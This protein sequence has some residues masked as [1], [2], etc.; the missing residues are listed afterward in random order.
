MFKMIKINN[1]FLIAIAGAVILHSGVLLACV[2]VSTPSYAVVSSSLA[3][4]VALVQ[5]SFKRVEKTS[6]SLME[7][8]VEKQQIARDIKKF[9]T[10]KVVE[11][12]IQEVDAL[13]SNEDL[14][15]VNVAP[16]AT[17]DVQAKMQ[18]NRPP[19]YPREAR[20]K[21]WEGRVIV[22]IFVT[23]TGVVKS[24]SVLESSGYKLLDNAA[25]GAIRKWLFEPA[26]LFGTPVEK[27]VEIPVR[28]ELK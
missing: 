3:I 28:F 14:S 7:E 2:F 13:S 1:D 12:A 17:T 19:I 27:R 21:G 25:V 20:R 6:E 16:G 4:E 23:Q 24:V 18:H 11:S 8:I 26:Q 22:E 15:R 10:E 5:A 9:D